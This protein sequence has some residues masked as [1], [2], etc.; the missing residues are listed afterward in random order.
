[1]PSAAQK[2]T[3]AIEDFHTEV[4]GEP[5]YRH[6]SAGLR[7]VQTE[8]GRLPGRLTDDDRSDEPEGG[9]RRDRPTTYRD[10]RERSRKMLADDGESND[11]RASA[12]SSPKKGDGDGAAR[13]EDS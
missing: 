6:V 12:S 4:G 1:M 8:I 10:A 9:E 11:E 3:Q 5:E 2:L 13:E 7:D